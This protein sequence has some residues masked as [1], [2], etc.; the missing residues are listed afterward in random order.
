MRDRRPEEEDVAGTRQ[1]LVHQILDIDAA[2]R[3]EPRI[4]GPQNPGT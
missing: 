2:G 3:Q 1:P 4:L